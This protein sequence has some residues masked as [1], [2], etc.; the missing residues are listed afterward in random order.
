MEDGMFY[1]FLESFHCQKCLFI[2]V[3]FLSVDGM[4]R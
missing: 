1:S 2:I 3:G 4:F